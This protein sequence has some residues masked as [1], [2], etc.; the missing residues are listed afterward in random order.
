[1]TQ[2]GNYFKHQDNLHQ[3]N[4]RSIP[5]RTPEGTASSQNN[6][7]RNPPITNNHSEDRNAPITATVLLIMRHTQSTSSPAEDQQ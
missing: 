4:S 1:M 6:K 5:Q 3:H 2:V 7:D